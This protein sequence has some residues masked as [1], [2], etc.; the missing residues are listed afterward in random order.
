METIEGKIKRKSV[1]ATQYGDRV[2]FMVGATW[3][4]A[5]SN[6]KKL[7]DVSKGLLKDLKEGDEAYF[8]IVENEGK[9]GEKYLNITDVV[10]VDREEAPPDYDD[11]EVQPGGRQP[12]DGRAKERGDTRVRSMV[13]SYG[14]VW[15]IEQ[16]KLRATMDSVDLLSY[17]DAVR[18]A[19]RYEQYILTGE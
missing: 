18:V 1:K 7:N 14:S 9:G 3:I 15:I 19:K 5:F 17:D 10:R 4:S 8:T 16:N 13:M 2:S 12:Q 6:D 11:E